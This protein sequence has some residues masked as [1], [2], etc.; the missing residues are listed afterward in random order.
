MSANN[1]ILGSGYIY[2]VKYQNSIPADDVLEVAE[3]QFGYTKGGA[4]LSYETDYT[5][6][7]DDNGQVKENFLTTDKCQLKLGAF[8]GDPEEILKICPTATRSTVDGVKT[9]KIGGVGRE[10]NFNWLVRFKHKTKPV[11]ITLIGKNTD[12]FELAFSADDAVKLEP[13]FTA[14]TMDNTGVLA[15]I[16]VD[17]NPAGGD[18]YQVVNIFADGADPSA[19]GYYEVAD[20]VYS[21]TADTEVE[22][23]KVY[24][25]KIR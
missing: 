21:A 25:T 18:V 6:I 16:R 10:Q 2:V 9:V 7:E 23:G 15:E 11:R 14:T 5:E 17:T 3:N 8:M 22:A 4:T 12:G 24:Y 13:T 1:I 19:L 20:G